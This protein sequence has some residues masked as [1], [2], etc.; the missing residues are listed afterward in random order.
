M[1]RPEGFY[2]DRYKQQA[3][4]KEEKQTLRETNRIIWTMAGH[5]ARN[6]NE[7]LSA[8]PNL[9]R[10]ENDT[11][12]TWLMDQWRKG[13]EEQDAKIRQPQIPMEVK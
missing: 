10:R 2:S 7:P 1:P 3:K 6:R 9:K 13:W 12:G 11:Y 8:C 4:K 5:I